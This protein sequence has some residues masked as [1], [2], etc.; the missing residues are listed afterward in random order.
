M[1]PTLIHV[2]HCPAA[3]TELYYFSPSPVNICARAQFWGLYS[4]ND[5][6]PNH[7]T[8]HGMYK[9]TQFKQ[10]IRTFTELRNLVFKYS[11]IFGWI[12]QICTSNTT[13]LLYIKLYLENALLV[14]TIRRMCFSWLKYVMSEF[15]R[16]SRT[17]LIQINWDSKPS[18]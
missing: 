11:S 17:P 5:P 14:S 4:S 8:W 15:F 7:F 16:Y 1:P 18:G 6:P 13:L 10:N 3:P 12:N 9:A 2:C